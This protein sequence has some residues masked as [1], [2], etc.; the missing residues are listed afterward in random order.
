MAKYEK[1]LGAGLGW[2]VGGPLGGLLGFVAGNLIE[3]ETGFETS[4]PTKHLTE[5]ELHLIVLASHLAKA[6]GHVTI[7]EV[8]FLNS[9]LNRHFDEKHSFERGQVIQHC[10]HKEYDL[11]AACDQIR[12]NTPLPTRIQV[13]HFLFDLATSDG[14]LS[15]RENYFIFR[16]AGYL[17]V[18]DVEFRKIK[19]EHQTQ[20]VSVYDVLEVKKHA[21]MSEVR[22]AYRRLVLKYHPDR[23]KHATD[24]EKKMLALKFQK[25]QE[26]YEQIKK[27][28]GEA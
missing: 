19:N 3:K 21:A 7:Q 17:T 26:A 2:V 18:N 27:E 4:A 20:H 12:M 5:F 10:L 1:W 16:I 28:R 15:E 11:A 13:V 6:D 14:A 9:F 25:I 24:A 23:N 8:N 22:T